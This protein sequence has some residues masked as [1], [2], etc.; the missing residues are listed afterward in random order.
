MIGSSKWSNASN[1]P[2]LSND[3]L[4]FQVQA[5]LAA[6][7]FAVTGHA[8][9]KR[10]HLQ[11]H[12]S[13]FIHIALIHSR[14]ACLKDSPC[15]TVFSKLPKSFLSHIPFFKPPQLL[16]VFQKKESQPMKLFGKPTLHNQEI[17]ILFMKL[18]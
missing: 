11:Q 7:T 2:L 4:L 6:N 9:N 14:I 5:S 13:I 8:E 12:F 17:R 18:G 15:S 1:Q 10:K 16:S 3:T